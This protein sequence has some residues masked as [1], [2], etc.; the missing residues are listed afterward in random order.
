METWELSDDSGRYFLSL[1]S[2]LPTTSR[3]VLAELV[4]L[5]YGGVLKATFSCVSVCSSVWATRQAF[6]L[7]GGGEAYAS[8]KEADA[9]QSTVI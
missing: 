6:R 3:D 4:G 2:L 9:P 5:I 8:Q 1:P 7:T